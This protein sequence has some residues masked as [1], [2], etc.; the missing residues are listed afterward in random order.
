MQKPEVLVPA[1]NL[2]E[3]DGRLDWDAT[4]RYAARAAATWVDYF[5]INGSTTR[6]D[7]LDA[8]ARADLLDLWIE[9][10]GTDRAIACTWIGEDVEAARVRGIRVMAV[11]QGHLDVESALDA[12]KQLPTG[13]L[14]YSHPMY[15]EVVLDS[16]LCAVAQ[17]HGVLP[18]GGKLAKISKTEIRAVRD[19]AGPAFRL[20]DG[21][22]RD[23]AG[24][25]AAGADGV[26]ATPLSS[27][28]SPFPEPRIDLLQMELDRLQGELDAL[29]DRAARSRALAASARATLEPLAG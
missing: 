3:V 16:R 8:E 29:P 10:V 5:I 19:V 24:S 14:V 12:L 13:S 23:I 15:S 22:C 20:W 18:A 6:G 21:S 11:L 7:L 4:R 27:L 9:A 1:L 2:Y 26:V 17:E 28:P 25:V